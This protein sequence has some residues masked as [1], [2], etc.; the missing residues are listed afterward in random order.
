[1]A[2]KG[3]IG[4]GGIIFWCFIGYQIFGGNDDADK[5]TTTEKVDFTTQVVEKAKEV[6]TEFDGVVKKAKEEYAKTETDPDP[7]PAKKVEDDPDDIYGSNDD[8]Y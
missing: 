2:S 7:I 5:N 6:K 3:G 4:I 1:M 8:Q